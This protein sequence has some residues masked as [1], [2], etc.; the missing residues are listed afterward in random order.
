MKSKN[1]NYGGKVC[2]RCKGKT[3]LGRVNK[4]FVHWRWRWWDRIQAIFSNLFYF[5]TLPVLSIPLNK[6][7][8]ILQSFSQ[9]VI[10]WWGP[11]SC[12]QFWHLRWCNSLNFLIFCPFGKTKNQFKDYLCRLLSNLE[13]YEENL[14]TKIEEPHSLRLA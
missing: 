11:F 2:L 5:N 7:P 4:L 8:V 3:L 12:R 9:W 13:F 6:L 10:G 14:I 1:S